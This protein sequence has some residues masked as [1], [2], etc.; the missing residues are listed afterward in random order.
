ME[1]PPLL[2]AMSH[3]FTLPEESRLTHCKGKRKSFWGI[4]L[5]MVGMVQKKRHILLLHICYIPIMEK[6]KMKMSYWQSL[7]FSLMNS[8]AQ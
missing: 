3:A 6:D 4:D 1:I 5:E 7:Q 2:Y 8:L